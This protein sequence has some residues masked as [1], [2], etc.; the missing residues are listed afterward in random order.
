MKKSEHSEEQPQASKPANLSSRQKDNQSKRREH[1]GA[2]APGID[3]GVEFSEEGSSDAQGYIDVSVNFVPIVPFDFEAVYRNLDGT[4][5]EEAKGAIIRLAADALGEML[6]WVQE[7]FSSPDSG[8]RWNPETSLRCKLALIRLYHSPGSLGNPTLTRL[9]EHLDISPQKLS[10]LWAEFKARFPG[11]RA[12]WEKSAR[13][14]EASR[15]AH[16]Q[17]A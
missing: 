12:P 2:P 13:A 11:V 17:A 16:R 10:V 15:K 4:N 9:A 1:A 5:G 6:G 3:Y 8:I 14:K 7:D